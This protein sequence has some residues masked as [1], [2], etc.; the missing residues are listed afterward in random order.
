MGKIKKNEC[1]QKLSFME[2]GLN[3]S[4]NVRRYHEKCRCIRRECSNGIRNILMVAVFLLQYFG[5]SDAEIPS[6]IRY[7]GAPHG[8]K[9][10]TANPSQSTNYK[11][12]FTVPFGMSVTVDSISGDSSVIEDRNGVWIEIS[13]KNKQGWAFSGLLVDYD[14]M[15]LI[16]KFKAAHNK[17]WT[18]MVIKVKKETAGNTRSVYSN[19]YYEK[20]EHLDNHNFKVLQLSR[21]FLLVEYI[22]EE[23]LSGIPDMYNVAYGIKAGVG[24]LIHDRL[25]KAQLAHLDKGNSL[26][27]IGS[28]G[29]CSTNGVLVYRGSTDSDDNFSKVLDTIF[30]NGL[31]IDTIGNCDALKIHW[32]HLQP[33]GQKMKGSVRFYC[34]QDSLMYKFT[35]N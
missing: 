2:K 11:L 12:I 5:L 9:V 21:D 28:Y 26:D 30:T 6:D 10:F 32:V 31:Y 25:N 22:C 16:N 24:E 33:D 19:Q 18:H 13:Y 29:C 20:K 23:P 17:E 34:K 27:L 8:I 14:P 4:R 1:T 15:D 3:I 35:T 7:V